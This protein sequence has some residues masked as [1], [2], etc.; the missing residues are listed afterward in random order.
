M[1]LELH[2]THSKSNKEL[3]RTKSSMVVYTLLSY[4]A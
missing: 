4:S 1:T 2:F 3:H